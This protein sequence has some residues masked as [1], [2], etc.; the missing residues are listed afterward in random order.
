MQFHANHAF[1]IFFLSSLHPNAL[2][3]YAV[4]LKKHQ[5]H[6]KDGGL[7]HAHYTSHIEYEIVQTLVT[8]AGTYF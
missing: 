7:W 5:K 6:Q 3:F 8:L 2:F 1:H 4:A